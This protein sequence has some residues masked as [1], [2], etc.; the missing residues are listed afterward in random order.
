M[1]TRRER[2]RLAQLADRLAR[3]SRVFLLGLI[4]ACGVEVLVDWNSTLFEINV[5]R[6]GMRQRG[7]NYVAILSRAALLPLRA[8]DQAALSHLSDGLFDDEDVV[9]V[10]IVDAAGAMRH[11]RLRAPYAASFQRRHGRPFLDSYQGQ[12]DRDLRGIREDPEGLARR[13]AQSR[14]RDFVQAWNDLVDRLM[15]VFVA[16]APPRSQNG[17]VLLYQDRLRTP[18][19]RHD[20]DLT[21]ALGVIRDPSADEGVVLVAFSMDRTNRAILKKYLKG[22]GMVLFFVTL[23]LVQSVLSRRDKLRLLELEGAQRQAREALA[24]ALP[25][26]L[27]LPGCRVTG[28]LRQA[29]GPVDGMRWDARAGD[30]WIEVLVVDPD[31]EG[32]PAAAAA[33]Q[34]QRTFRARAEAGVARSDLLEEVT[35]LGEAAQRIPLSRPVGLVLLRVELE[36]GVLRAVSSPLGGLRSVAEGVARLNECPL[37]EVPAGVVGPLR[38]LSGALPAQGLLCAVFAGL[39]RRDAAQRERWAD[40]VADYLLRRRRGAGARSEEL[41]QDA[42]TWARGRST[43][44]TQSDVL[45]LTL[46]KRA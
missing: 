13:M 22:A 42:A 44:L 29:E 39:T 35:A 2:G 16:P 31:G 17:Q 36:S 45:V 10:R 14:H 38:E 1:M 15:R 19:R 37:E 18:E 40:A 34:V 23:I 41:C 20:S 5:L 27:D 43:R 24:D 8:G 6:D 4:V 26:P 30:T 33:L 46:E 32:V 9:F 11:E 7:L 3:S 21:Y 25:P 28:A 12:M